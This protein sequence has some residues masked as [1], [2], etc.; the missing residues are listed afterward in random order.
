MPAER[1]PPNA[2]RPLSARVFFALWPPAAVADTLAGVACTLASRYGGRP[3]RRD[4][5]HLT[6]AFLGDVPL[7]ALPRLRA[8][9]RG[10]QANC[11]D[12]SLDHLAY[13]AHN[14]LLWAGCRTTP[15]GLTDLHGRLHTALGEGGFP[16][17]PPGRRFTPHV[18]LVRKLDLAES[19]DW[20]PLPSLIWHC[21]SFVLVQSALR[22][23]GPH[24]RVIEN[25][26][27]RCGV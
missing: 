2:E 5:I 11:F 14:H 9:G 1:R 16:V 6:L 25:F 24:Y 23:E 21:A 22:P 10:L 12:L 7:P 26:P 17:D 18:T 19:T 20:P 13:W 27:L 15:E 8:L 3:T 4:T